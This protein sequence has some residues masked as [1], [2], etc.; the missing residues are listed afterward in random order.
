MP[1]STALVSAFAAAALALVGACTVHHHHQN[2]AHP[3]AAGQS[4]QHSDTP[5]AA[6]SPYQN[7]YSAPGQTWQA[8][9]RA[10]PRPYGADSLAVPRGLAPSSQRYS[11]CDCTCPNHGP[12][13]A[14]APRTD[15]A[16]PLEFGG[17][18]SNYLE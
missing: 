14:H 3:G 18:P 8:E 4:Y 15:A 16:P 13:H 17:D 10:N 1:R 11:G 5:P 12:S 2:G 9:R 6:A 7:Q